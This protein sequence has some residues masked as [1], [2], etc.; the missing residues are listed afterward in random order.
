MDSALFKLIFL[1]FRAF[2]RRMAGGRST[3]KRLV[4]FAFGV[5]VV[6]M[7]LFAV[8]KARQSDP[9]NV[10]TAMPFVL[11]GI[12]LLTIITSAGDKAIAFTPGEIDFL[13]AAPFTRRQ[14]IA[15]KLLKSFLIALMTAL[16]LSFVMLHNA[17]WWPACYVGI[18]LSLLFIQLFS[19]NAVIIAQTA[20][21]RAHSRVRQVVLFGVVAA[22]IIVVR[23]YIVAAPQ[24]HRPIEILR[25]LEVSPVGSVVLAPFQT[26][27]E[28]MTA[29][30]LAPLARS[31]ALALIVNGL[32][33]T[34][35]FSLD[36]AYTEAAMSASTRRYAQLQRIRGGSM[37]SIGAGK[38]ARFHVPAAPWLAGI[39]P[40]AWRQLIS[41]TRSARGLLL[42]L[43]I[44][45]IGAGPTLASVSSTTDAPHLTGV[46]IGFML[47]L[48]ILISTMLKFDFRGDLDQMQVLKA[49]PIHPA[50]LA[51]G[52]ILIP[53]TML[54]T[55]HLFVLYGAARA[56]PAYQ[57]W[58]IVG[59]LLA[60][61]VDLLLFAIENLIFL[62]FPS[63][64]AAA[65][66]GDFQ[67]LGRQ[68]VVMAI[69]MFVLVIACMPPAIISGFI[70]VFSGNS[71]TALV[72]SAVPL[73]L[74]ETAGL[75]PLMA[76]AFNRYDPSVD[77]PG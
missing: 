73:L 66:P 42:L 51:I 36:S 25:E 40:I 5:V 68:V 17:R 10:Q 35:V 54:A 16:F 55:M 34:L 27:G 77:T 43:L 63:R 14:L 53:T 37:L 74:A 56:M 67:V 57:S 47:W 52:Q 8:M 75:V 26:F 13:F 46:F 76:W 38:T 9:D 18:F 72:A 50:S 33:L 20:G 62:L 2:C 29:P 65:S 69:K 41:A 3:P 49:L 48:T 39:G 60:F 70:Y 61:P 31:A 24:G 30:G 58:L 6:L 12:C 11:L 22:V 21:T 28:T 45:G 19:I 23:E 64:P 1:Q 59:C 71:Q 32:L 15:Y 4:T 44:V 7:W